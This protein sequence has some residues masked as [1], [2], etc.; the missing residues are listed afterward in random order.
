[1]FC[2]PC[3]GGGFGAV[4]VEPGIDWIGAI[5]PQLCSRSNI[6]GSNQAFVVSGCRRAFL[7]VLASAAD[8]DSG[9]SRAKTGSRR[10]GVG[11][12]RVWFVAHR[13]CA[14]WARTAVD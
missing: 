7:L 2:V 3:R 14:V 5:F 1:M 4:S 12:N 8:V 10:C 13:E 11:R 6:G 9:A